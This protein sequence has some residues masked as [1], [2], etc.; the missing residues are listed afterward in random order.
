MYYVIDNEA[1]FEH[2]Y[3]IS[4]TITAVHVF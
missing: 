2:I 4:I 1:V 3:S